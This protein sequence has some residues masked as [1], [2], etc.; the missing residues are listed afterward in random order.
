M[1][2]DCFIEAGFPPFIFKN[3]RLPSSL[4]SGVIKNHN[5]SGVALTGS[6]KAG[7]QVA[8]ISGKYLKKTVLEL[9]GMIHI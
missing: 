5:V 7:K 1:I 9:V 6:T 8:K 3:L 4:I 2:K